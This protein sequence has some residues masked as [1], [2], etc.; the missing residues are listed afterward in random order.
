VRPH[1]FGRAVI[2]VPRVSCARQADRD[3]G[4]PNDRDGSQ[5][6][7]EHSTPLRDAR[8]RS[9]IVTHEQGIECNAKSQRSE[10]ARTSTSIMNWNAKSAPLRITV[11]MNQELATYHINDHLCLNLTNSRAPAARQPRP[12]SLTH[13]LETPI[14][15]DDCSWTSHDWRLR[16]NV[17]S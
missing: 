14:E 4:K 15:I 10:T 17:Q 13:R 7:G 8:S 2:H 16:S 5:S 11:C 9:T 6:H 3:T 1:G 12:P